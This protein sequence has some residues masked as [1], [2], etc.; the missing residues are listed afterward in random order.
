MSAHLVAGWLAD[1]A[2]L[3]VGLTGGIASGKSAAAAAFAALGV[4][5]ID[6]D[7]IAHELTAPG[8]PLLAPIAS[9]F[10]AGVLDAEGRLD[11]RALRTRVFAD[12]GER[13][14]LEALLHPAILESMAQ[15]ARAAR[16]EYLIFVVPLLVERDLAGLFDRVLVIDCPVELQ[17]ARLVAR[18]GETPAGALRIVE[19]QASR[20]A[21]A[22]VADDLLDN[23][24]SSAALE[25]EVARLHQAYCAEARRA[26]FPRAGRGGQN[27]AP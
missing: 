11:R 7:A 21:R 1:D 25:A 6:A 3:R 17:T 4:P 13:A 8:S 9:R 10:G 19:A 20:A 26:P 27:S 5:V 18:D 14:A 15:R 24:G 12:V 2:R 23:R 22:A 16:G